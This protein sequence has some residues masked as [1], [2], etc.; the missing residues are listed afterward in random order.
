MFPLHLLIKLA[1]K[2]P[3]KEKITGYA[4][5]SPWCLGDSMPLPVSKRKFL[6]SPDFQGT[7]CISVRFADTFFYLFSITRF[8]MTQVLIYHL[9]LLSFTFLFHYFYFFF[10][11]SFD[12]LQLNTT[13]SEQCFNERCSDSTVLNLNVYLR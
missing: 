9:F 13:K 7:V 4:L 10:L 2:I 1:L 12:L 8:T 6:T 3:D 5:Q 11:F